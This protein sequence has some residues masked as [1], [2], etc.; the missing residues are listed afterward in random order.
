LL[1]LPPLPN[2]LPLLSVYITPYTSSFFFT[3]CHFLSLKYTQL[4]LTYSFFLSLSLSL[5]ISIS[6]SLLY[7]YSAASAETPSWIL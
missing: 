4:L 3:P 5:S 2:P 1:L 7:A 6:L